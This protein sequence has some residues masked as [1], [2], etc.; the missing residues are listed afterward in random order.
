NDPAEYP[1]VCRLRHLVA[2]RPGRLAWETTEFDRQIFELGSTDDGSYFVVKG[3]GGPRVELSIAV[4]EGATGKKRWA[5]PVPRWKPNYLEAWFRVDPTGTV[6][7]TI[8]DQAPALMTLRDLPTGRPLGTQAVP[9]N[10]CS[11]GPGGQSWF[12][13]TTVA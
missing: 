10:P 9:Q 5:V 12:D 8:T 4:F 7:G 13:S 6:I 2:G 3:A 1:R 11:I